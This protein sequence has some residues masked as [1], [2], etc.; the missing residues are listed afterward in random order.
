MQAPQNRSAEIPE[1]FWSSLR[2]M[3]TVASQ[4]AA[5]EKLLPPNSQILSKS[6]TFH[7]PL[8]HFGSG[9]ETGIEI[10]LYDPT[11]QKCRLCRSVS[12]GRAENVCVEILEI[13]RKFSRKKVGFAGK[14]FLEKRRCPHGNSYNAQG[15]TPHGSSHSNHIQPQMASFCHV[16]GKSTHLVR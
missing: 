6:D 4:R 15:R 13:S 16:T 14:V 1:I 9:T 10:F 5:G 3:P 8:R 2:N 11:S 7:V 12:S